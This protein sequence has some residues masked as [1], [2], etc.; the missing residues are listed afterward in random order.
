MSVKKF[1]ILLKNSLIINDIKN[2]DYYYILRKNDTF[3]P[4]APKYFIPCSLDDAQ[5]LSNTSCEGF[6]SNPIT[7]NY[8]L[9]RSFFVNP[10]SQILDM[11]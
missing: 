9:P 7:P 11:K 1:K 5:K 2:Q 4:Y 8:M 10:N 6:Y 3:N